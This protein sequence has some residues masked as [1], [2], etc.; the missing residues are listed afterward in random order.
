MKRKLKNKKIIKKRIL[1]NN[2]MKTTMLRNQNKIIFAMVDKER[3]E[4]PK[5]IESFA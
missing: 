4:I 3:A 1:S 5:H 2:K